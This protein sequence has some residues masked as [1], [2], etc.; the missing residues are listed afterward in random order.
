MYCKNQKFNCK[1]VLTYLL[2]FVAMSFVFVV[3]TDK[4]MVFIIKDFLY[5]LQL[6]TDVYTFLGRIYLGFKLMMDIPSSFA[7]FL[8]LI[9]L[10]CAT[11]TLKTILFNNCP[12]RVFV[13]E[14]KIESPKYRVESVLF[15][16]NFVYLENLR[17]LN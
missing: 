6:G 16:K 17:L 10:V 7:L 15:A 4:Q 5:S 1:I 11:I 3:M 2:Q 9:Q 12:K 8:F 13:E 14:Q